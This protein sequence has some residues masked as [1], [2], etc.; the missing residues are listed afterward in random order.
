MSEANPGNTQWSDTEPGNVSKNLT[1][2]KKLWNI[3]WKF[4][5]RNL[6]ICKIE[7]EKL[8]FGQLKSFQSSMLSKA[9]VNED[10]IVDSHNEWRR[11]NCAYFKCSTIA[12][13][14]SFNS[15]PCASV[16]MIFIW[17]VY[18]CTRFSPR[19]RQHSDKM[20]SKENDCEE[21][22]IT[23]RS[24]LQNPLHDK[25][26]DEIRFWA[27]EETKKKKKISKEKK[28]YE[29]KEKER[30]RPPRICLIQ[31]CNDIFFLHSFFSVR[32]AS[33]LVL[34]LIAVADLVRF[35][36]FFRRKLMSLSR[37]WTICFIAS[38]NSC[39]QRQNQMLD[40]DWR[41]DEYE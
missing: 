24:F 7:K 38:R 28:I 27:R 18:V 22:K 1:Q 2:E 6:L 34:V 19:N 30:V 11:C 3:N 33:I 4:I 8:S 15:S 9:N 35:V 40:I 25:K 23:K 39:S 21:T 13:R 26:P 12:I 10:D 17:I 16:Q 36:Y 41:R 20:K 32:F 29:R 37:L 14:F 5:H 31:N